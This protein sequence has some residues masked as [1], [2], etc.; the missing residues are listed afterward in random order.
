MRQAIAVT[1]KAPLPGHVKTRLCGVLSV[2]DAAQLYRCFLKDSLALVE[3]IAGIEVLLSYTPVGFE[4]HFDG[5][6]SSSHRLLAQR[7]DDL[8]DKLI[9][10]FE[11]LFDEG[12]ESAALMNAD[13]PT[14]PRR[15]IAQALDELRRPGDR[16]VLGPAEDGGYYLVGLKRLHRRLFE[17]ITWSSERVLAETLERA[18][19]IG[20]EVSLLPRWYD[21]DSAA[22]FERLKQ[23][24]IKATSLQDGKQ[25]TSYDGEIALTAVN[26]RDFILSRW[27]ND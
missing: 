15:Y 5:I 20:L 8:G 10:A 13:S 11:D 2:D 6:I 27:A 12:F 3:A 24:M 16:V 23:E 9:H 1:A 22:E 21:V 19:E 25:N 14:L 7:G 18:R 17:Q 26:T 4:S